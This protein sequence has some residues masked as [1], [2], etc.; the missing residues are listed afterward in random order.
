MNVILLFTDGN[1]IDF[2]Q[3][4]VIYKKTKEMICRDIGETKR[5][6]GQSFSGDFPFIDAINVKA[7]FYAYYDLS[8]HSNWKGVDV[9]FEILTDIAYNKLKNFFKRS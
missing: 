5:L 9:D 1:P 8:D 3:K 7:I 4:L 6:K 2:L